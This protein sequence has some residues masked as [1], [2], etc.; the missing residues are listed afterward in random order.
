[1]LALALCLPHDLANQINSVRRG[2]GVLGGESD[3][4]DAQNGVLQH[5]RIVAGFDQK[6][7]VGFGRPVVAGVIRF[8]RFQKQDLETTRV[9]KNNIESLKITSSH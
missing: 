5:G 7:P 9:I 6:R 1:V 8:N 4:C 2:Q 3:G